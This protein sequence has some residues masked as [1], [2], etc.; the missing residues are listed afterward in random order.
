MGLFLL[1][2]FGALFG[3]HLFGKIQMGKA[4]ANYQPPPVTVT[5]ITATA[6]E[7]PRALEAIG[8]LEAIHQ[9]T[10]APEIDGRITE[11]HIAPGAAVKAG[12]ALIQLNDG[13][14]QG[15]LQRLRAQ[16]KLARI[17]LERSTKLLGLAVSQS[18]IDAQQATLDE[19]NGE[20]AR[21]QA[22]IAQKLIRAPFTGMLGVQRVH[23]GEFVKQGDPLVTLTDLSTLY[24]N[25]TLPEQAH[26]QLKPGLTVKFVVDALPKREFSAKIIAVEP[27]IGAD[28]RSIKLQ[29]KLDNPKG[30]LASG[31]FARASL[32]LP[33]E[34]NVVSIPTIA[35]DY[36]IHGD[37]VYVVQR[38][39]TEHGEQ[40]IAKR[41]LVKTDGQFGDSVIVRSGVKPGETVVT[42]GQ[43]KLH[44]GA[45][46]EIVQ[47]TTLDNIAAKVQSRPE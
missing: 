10:I 16:A 26:S 12:Q 30:E 19:V 1:V 33:T 45:V 35:I 2:F 39:N 28:T 21:T 38:Q 3:W 29:A 23:V 46:V 15:D 14:E 27:Q 40:Q 25:L 9:V 7:I 5:A 6:R 43:M 41:V 31:M 13:P 18:E 20:I 36:S 8:S 42:A 32:Q 22:L 4:M 47:N 24:L 37:S 34:D 44:D 11:L 17:N